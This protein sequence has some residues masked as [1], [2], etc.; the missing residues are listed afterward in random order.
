[1]ENARQL[2]RLRSIF[3]DLSA[4][5]NFTPVP[6]S[7]SQGFIDHERKIVVYTDHQIFQRYHKYK[8]KQAYSKG[9]AITLKAL[10]ELQPGDY[11]THIDHGLGVYSGLQKIEVNG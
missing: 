10:K 5:I 6:A 9:K 1:A 7:I 3:D 4:Q 11:V 8:I 2:E